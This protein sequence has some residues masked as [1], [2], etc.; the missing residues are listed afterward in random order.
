MEEIFA[1]LA[2]VRNTDVL[3]QSMGS[4]FM[5]HYWNMKMGLIGCLAASVTNNNIR[6]ITSQKSEDLIYTATEAW[7][8]P[9]IWILQQVK[10]KKVNFPLEQAMM[11]QRGGGRSVAL[12]FL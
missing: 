4:I 11:A 10:V 12:L 5:G 7:N 2:C 8:Y 9:P 1:F 6:C 3:G